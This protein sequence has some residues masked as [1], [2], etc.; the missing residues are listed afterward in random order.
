M[1]GN[2]FQIHSERKNKS[3]FTETIE[4]LRVYSS[5]EYKNDIESLTILFAELKTPGVVKPDDPEETITVNDDGTT[6]TTISKFEEM[7]Y[8]E[9]IKQW[10]R[11]DKSLKTTIRSLHNIVWGQCSR[12]IKNQLM[13]EKNFNDIEKDGDVTELLKKN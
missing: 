2:V 1:N 13:M 6:T 11:D 3:Q 5:T 12:L 4:A 8:T 9:R 10:I 7:T